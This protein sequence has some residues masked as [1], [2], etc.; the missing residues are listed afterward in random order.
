MGIR[1]NDSVYRKIGPFKVIIIY[2]CIFLVASLPFLFCRPYG[3]P[4]FFSTTFD[5]S[6][7]PPQND[8]FRFDHPMLPELINGYRINYYV[9]LP[10]NVEF[11]NFTVQCNITTYA[12]G[13]LISTENV[14]IDLVFYP[15]KIVSAPL[16]KER[17]MFLEK[18]SYTTFNFSTSLLGIESLNIAVSPVSRLLSINLLIQKFIHTLII[19]TLIYH[20]QKMR[21]YSK[22]GDSLLYSSKLDKYIIFGLITAILHID[23]FHA[24]S[25]SQKIFIPHYVSSFYTALFPT[26]IVYYLHL[27]LRERLHSIWFPQVKKPVAIMYCTSF[28][29][30]I[31]GVNMLHTGIHTKE[32]NFAQILLIIICMI[33]LFSSVFYFLRVPKQ[34]NDTNRAN[35]YLF[36]QII[37]V[38]FSL[39]TLVLIQNKV[40]NQFLIHLIKIWFTT[41]LSGWLVIKR[42]KN[43]DS[44][45]YIEVYIKE[46]E[47][48]EAKMAD[49]IH[50]VPFETYDD[51]KRGKSPFYSRENQSDTFQNPSFGFLHNIKK[52]LFESSSTYT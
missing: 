40:E 10:N 38:Y 23:S 11:K 29:I 9:V 47:L 6:L 31:F 32:Q 17:H 16:Y 33:P 51:S 28:M 1:I 13:I 8:H 21:F 43:E 49:K 12:S 19:V 2:I 18:N 37:C 14:D 5:S 15:K 25:I 3:L 27:M 50:E 48:H 46:K 4:I 44:Q 42:V 39:I 35:K 26:F 45:H 41:F 30:S 24:V 34:N 7:S 52:G 22:N 20:I 36:F